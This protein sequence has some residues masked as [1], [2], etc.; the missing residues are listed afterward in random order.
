MLDQHIVTM[1]GIQPLIERRHAT[2]EH[3]A[4]PSRTGQDWHREKL[5]RH[6]TVVMPSLRGQ[7][8]ESDL[9]VSRD[10]D[11]AHSVLGHYGSDSGE[12]LVACELHDLCLRAHTLHKLQM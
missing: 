7:H 9:G 3:D 8:R 4:L 12:L 10:L 11:E 1:Q 2:R 6:R 5:P